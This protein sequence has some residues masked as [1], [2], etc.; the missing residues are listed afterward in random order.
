[1]REYVPGVLVRKRRDGFHF[2]NLDVVN[3]NTFSE[4][5]FIML[6]GL[7][8]FDADKIMAY[9][10][11]KVKKLE[12]VTRRYYMGVLSLPGIVSYTTYAGD[13]SGFNIDP[14]CVVM[15]Y[16]GLQLQREY[17][18]PRYENSKQRESRMPDQR[19]RLFW[20]P[21]VV[22]DSKGKQFIEF[23]TSDLTGDYEVLIEGISPAGAVGFGASKFEV[24]SLND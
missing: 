13:L 15:D 6:D 16:E 20:N 3:K 8:I 21:A 18:T 24:V 22:T 10:P 5:P 12:V 23:Y 2:I 11:L 4:D 19:D 1:M 17:Y 14:H 9:D 7:P